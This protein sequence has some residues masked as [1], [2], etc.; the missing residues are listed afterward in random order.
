MGRIAAV[1]LLLALAWLLSPSPSWAAGASSAASRGPYPEDAVKAVFLYRFAGYVQWPPAAR[2]GGQFTI[3]V[4][5]GDAVAE[6]LRLLLPDHP[7]QTRPAQ[8][9]VIT[10]IQQLDGAQMLYIGPDYEGSLSALIA[11]LGGRPVLVVTDHPQGLDD[12]ATVNFLLDGQHVRFDVSTVAAT[13]SGLKISSALL[14]VAEHVKTGHLRSGSAC[15]RAALRNR[16]GRVCLV[17]VASQ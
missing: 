15:D 5:G 14:A 16:H 2:S 6:Q 13:R 10:R 11:R 17:R 8:V 7:I 4:L 3:A 12:G 9:R 1:L